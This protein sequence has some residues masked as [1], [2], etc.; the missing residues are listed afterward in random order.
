[1]IATNCPSAIASPSATRISFTTPALGDSTGISIFI[2]SRIMS[3]PSVSILSPGLVRIFQTLPAISDFTFT[4]AKRFLPRWSFL[5]GHG[6]GQGK[7]R[8]AHTQAQ[9]IGG[10]IDRR[11]SSVLRRGAPIADPRRARRYGR[12]RHVRLFE[13][14][15]AQHAA[16]IDAGSAVVEQDQAGPEG[17]GRVAGD[18]RRMTAGREDAVA[19]LRHQQGG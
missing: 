8:T 7:G 12:A 16:A 9:P 2:D 17:R 18:Q 4:M 3:S 11:Q 10:L 19:V 15:E 5:V 1:M 14:V 13:D 6:A